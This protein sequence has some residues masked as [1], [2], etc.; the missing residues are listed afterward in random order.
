MFNTADIISIQKN[1]TFYCIRLMI[2]YASTT[3]NSPAFRKSS[4]PV[5]VS[6]IDKRAK[7]L[8]NNASAN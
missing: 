8:L 4:S 3:P 1:I 2:L 7:P 5:T 6:P